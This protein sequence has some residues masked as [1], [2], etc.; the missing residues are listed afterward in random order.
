[1]DFKKLILKYQLENDLKDYEMAAR[2]GIPKTAFSDFF[3]GRKDLS[4]GAKINL[5]DSL[6]YTFSRDLIISILPNNIQETVKKGEK[7]RLKN[8]IKKKIEK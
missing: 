5:L 4:L 3:A 8:I 2:L 6:G 1:M 7:E